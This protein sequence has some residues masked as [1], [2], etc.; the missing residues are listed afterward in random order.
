MRRSFGQEIS[1]NRVRGGELSSETRSAIIAKVEAGCTHKELAAEFTCSTRTIRRT[2]NRWKNHNTTN[3]LPRSGRPEKLNRREKRA[4]LR[5]A[6]RAP[7]IQYARLQEET[8]TTYVH[9]R[10]IYRLLKKRGLRNYRCKQRPKFN[11]EHASLRLQFSRKYRNFN[12]RRRTVKFSDECS[13]Q[14]GSGAEAE[15]CFRY[16]NEKWKKEMI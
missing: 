15:W 2:I 13:V 8:D 5:A 16:P 4:I 7:K 6:R 14:R 9:R 12:F 10:T 11:R 3:S 1:G